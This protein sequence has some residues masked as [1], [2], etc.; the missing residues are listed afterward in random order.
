MPDLTVDDIKDYLAGRVAY[1]DGVLKRIPQGAP[2]QL[3]LEMHQATYA[4]MLR[5]IEN[6]QN[7]IGG[8]HPLREIKV[9]SAN[10]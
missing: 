5:W 9:E 7:G 6:M 8:T 2:R 4:S 1:L 10:S 3:K